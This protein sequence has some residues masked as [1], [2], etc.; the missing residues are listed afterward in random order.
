M[1]IG[2]WTYES[3]LTLEDLTM[4]F[5]YS[6]REFPLEDNEV[7]QIKFADGSFLALSNVNKIGG[8]CDDCRCEHID[9]IV[10]GFRLITL[11]EGD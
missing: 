2:P 7:I 9:R 6:S 1:K 10:I 11:P 8:I 4:R 3:S 5:G